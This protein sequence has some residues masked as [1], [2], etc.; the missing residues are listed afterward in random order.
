MILDSG[1]A[2]QLPPF[3]F[4]D[5]LFGLEPEEE[6]FFKAETGIQDPEELKKHAIEVHEEAYKVSTRLL[7][8]WSSATPQ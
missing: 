3:P 4:D 8:R 2:T 1:T 6:A 7:A 5:T